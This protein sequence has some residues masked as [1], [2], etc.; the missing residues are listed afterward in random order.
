MSRSLSTI[1]EDIRSLPADERESLLRGLIA[2]LDSAADENVEAAWLE[3]AHRRLHEIESGSVIP[4][5]ADEVIE[6][7]RKQLAG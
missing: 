1:Q 4:I 2:D 6:R 7:I 3:E 5:P